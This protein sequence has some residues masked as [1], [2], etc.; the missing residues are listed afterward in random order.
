MSIKSNRKSLLLDLYGNDKRNVIYNLNKNDKIKKY[1]KSKSL[2][3]PDIKFNT[4]K[5]N[6]VENYNKNNEDKEKSIISLKKPSLKYNMSE[7][8]IPT[9]KNDN[10]I[11]KK[12]PKRI[13]L[14]NK[15]Y[16]ENNDLIERINKYKIKNNKL[17]LSSK[18]NL[19]NYQSGLVDFAYENCSHESINHLMNNLK[20][21]NEQIKFKFSFQRSRWE[22]VAEKLSKSVP[23]FL[24]EKFYKMAEAQKLKFQKKE[25]QLEPIKNIKLLKIKE[26][27]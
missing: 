14:L 27:F 8:T 15:L 17:A 11:N 21:L 6:S 2:A 9:L 20:I 25:K 18:F 1:S 7:N 10:I 19:I 13:R 22:L 5:V 4:L 12:L 16:G 24:T 3:L 23:K 26:N